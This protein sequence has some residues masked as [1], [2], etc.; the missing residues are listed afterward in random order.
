[1]SDDVTV[2][3]DEI[4]AYADGTVARVR[5]LAVPKST[6]FPEEVKYSFHYGVAGG[7]NPYIRLDNHHGVHELHLGSRTYEGD[8]PGLQ[9]LYRAWRAALPFEKRTDW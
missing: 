9:T 4:E 1:M 3:R 8:F 7:E 2:V 5:V 6:K